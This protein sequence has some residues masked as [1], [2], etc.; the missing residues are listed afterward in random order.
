MS[1][2]EED[3]LRDNI[4]TSSNVTLN[5]GDF[6]AAG[7]CRV[8]FKAP[9][10]WES[11]PALW[12]AQIESQFMIAGLSSDT[13]KFHAVV[14][15]LEPKV[16]NCVRDIVIKPPTN[17]AYEALKTRVLNF[18]EQSESSKLKLLLNDLQLGDRRPSQLLCEMEALNNG[19]LNRDALKALWMQRL[20]SNVQQILSVCS[21][22]VEESS[23]LSRIADKVYEGSQVTASNFAAVGMSSSPTTTVNLKSIGIEDLRNDIAELQKAISGIQVKSVNAG[24]HRSRSPS[25]SL[26]RSRPSSADRRG[27]YCWYHAK[28]RE[29]AHKC[30]SPCNWSEN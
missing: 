4:K 13:T 6:T 30:R 28:F 7:I 2:G 5:S 23:K 19:K 18:Y 21:D 22:E 9:I 3:K 25:R 10:F 27:S 14:A 12:F 20:P 24:A 11:D 8:A 16:L 17:N 26:V 15:A 1:D 29:R